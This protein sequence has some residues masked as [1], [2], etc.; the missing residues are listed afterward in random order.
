VSTTA[1]MFAS[2]IGIAGMCATTIATIG[3]TSIA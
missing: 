3:T 2:P 1:S